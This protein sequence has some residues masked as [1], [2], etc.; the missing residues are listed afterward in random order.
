MPVDSFPETNCVPRWLKH[1]G[2]RG[3]V[4]LLCLSFASYFNST[5]QILLPGASTEDPT[6]DKVMQ[7]DLTDK[8]CQVSRGPLPEHLPWNQNLSV[9]CLLYYNLLT[10]QGAIPD[11]LSLEKFNLELQLVSCIWKE[12]FSSNP[13][14]GSLTCLIGLTTH[15]IVYGPPTVR[16]MHLKDIEPFLK[17]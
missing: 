13:F 14:D 5:F 1:P 2:I 7:R 17:S 15:V 11:H 12:C 4:F 8:V 6:H 16:G 10:L 3:V 9:Y